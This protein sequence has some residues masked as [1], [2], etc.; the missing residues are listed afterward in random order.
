MSKILVNRVK[1]A[2]P[3]DRTQEKWYATIKSNSTV[4]LRALSKM[5]SKNTTLAEGE[6]YLVLTELRTVIAECLLGGSTV[7]ID[8]FGSMRLI[9]QSTGVENKEDCNGSCITNV[10]PNFLPAAEFREKLKKANFVLASSLV[11][12]KEE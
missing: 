11:T 8:D 3:Q 4:D 6:V 10:K 2:N 1:R 7:K 9:A 12:E 5:L